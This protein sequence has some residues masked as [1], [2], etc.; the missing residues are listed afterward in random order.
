MEKIAEKSDS[1][2]DIFDAKVNSNLGSETV[3]EECLGSETSYFSPVN[4]KPTSKAITP[5][6]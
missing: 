6:I 1:V 5:R 2:H 4:S 3:S